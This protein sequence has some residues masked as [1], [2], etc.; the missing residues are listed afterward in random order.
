MNN[1]TKRMIELMDKEISMLAE[2]LENKIQQRNLIVGI[3]TLK[4][5][6]KIQN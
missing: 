5:L 3:D 2:L 6:D 4:T 1:D